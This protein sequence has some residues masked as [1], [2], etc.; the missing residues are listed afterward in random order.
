[1]KW[2]KKKDIDDSGGGVMA[3]VKGNQSF[4]SWARQKLFNHDDNPKMYI[5]I[6]IQHT[7]HNQK[8]NPSPTL[9]YNIE[10]HH[11]IVD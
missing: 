4:V 2:V 8:Q 6:A 7:W 11:F 9:Y 5:V 10:T 1:L 3:D